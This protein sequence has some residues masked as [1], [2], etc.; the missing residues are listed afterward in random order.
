MTV[1]FPKQEGDHVTGR[2]RRLWLWVCSL[3]A[4]V[5]G[6]LLVRGAI[7]QAIREPPDYAEIERGLFLG[8]RV[9]GPPP[10]TQAVLNLCALEDGYTVEVC[11]WE[12]IRDAEPAPSL[13]WLSRQV[14]FVEE[15]RRAGRT[16]Y[17]H[18][19]NGVSRSAMV[20][21]A[22]LMQ[23][24]GWSRDEALAFARARRPVVRPN[25]AFMGLLLEWEQYLQAH[26]ARDTRASQ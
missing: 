13:D 9:E 18:C 20:V 19:R 7:Y 24:R 8:A 23:T 17:V 12:P 5:L 15:Q 11:R 10:G 22:Y 16:V 14:E 3:S 6:A 21:L 4:L 25:P 2:S 1:G 26:G